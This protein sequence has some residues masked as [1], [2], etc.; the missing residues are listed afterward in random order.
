MIQSNAEKSF[1]SLLGNA[2]PFVLRG[3]LY[4]ISA[5]ATWG[6]GNVAFNQL[7]AD[8]VTWLPVVDALTANG[9]STVYLPTGEFQLAPSSLAVAASG[10]LTS[11]ANYSD[12]ETVTIGTRVYTLQAA[13]TAG[14]GHVLIGADEATTITNLTNAINDSGGVPGTD[15]NVVAPDPNVTAVAAAHTVTVTAKVPG[16]AANADA[17]TETAADAA[18]GHATLTDGTDQSPSA[19]NVDIARIPLGPF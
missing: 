13:L 7:G 8:G 5:I 2:G 14:D 12:G 1:R 17:T 3:G 10:V 11:S 6:G 15:Y 16:A 19:L 18:W 9:V 4:Q